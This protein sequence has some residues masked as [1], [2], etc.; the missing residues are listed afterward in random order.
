MVVVIGLDLQVQERRGS[1]LVAPPECLLFLDILATYEERPSGRQVRSGAATLA[2]GGVTLA[3]PL[4]VALGPLAI[5]A[6]T[7][8][9]ARVTIA[10]LCARTVGDDLRVERRIAGKVRCRGTP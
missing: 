7:F 6:G 8:L 4:P 1:A 10:T 2:V 5:R 3:A 9:A